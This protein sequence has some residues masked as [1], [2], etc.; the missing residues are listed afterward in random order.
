MANFAVIAGQNRSGHWNSAC[1]PCTAHRVMRRAVLWARSRASRLSSLW[2]AWFTCWVYLCGSGCWRVRTRIARCTVGSGWAWSIWVLNEE[3][4]WRNT[5][6]FR[7]LRHSPPFLLVGSGRLPKTSNAVLLI[8]WAIHSVSWSMATGDSWSGGLVWI[9]DSTSLLNLCYARSDRGGIRIG[10]ILCKSGCEL[11]AVEMSTATGEWSERLYWPGIEKPLS[12]FVRF[13]E[14]K[15]ASI[16]DVAGEDRDAKVWTVLFQRRPA[17]R[18]SARS[19]RSAIRIPFGELV[20]WSTL[21]SP[22]RIVN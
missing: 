20:R 16:L 19:S 10:L 1:R 22:P 15:T 9:L 5:R 18:R 8:V 11:Y 13:A 17:S 3:R 21:W 6:S 14:M 2:S 12:T 7:I 4:L